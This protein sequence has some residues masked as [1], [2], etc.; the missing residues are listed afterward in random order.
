MCVCVS[1]SLSLSLSLFL[2]LKIPL[3]AEAILIEKLSLYISKVK[4]SIQKQKKNSYM[5]YIMR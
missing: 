5:I 4:L 1:L 3:L 2:S